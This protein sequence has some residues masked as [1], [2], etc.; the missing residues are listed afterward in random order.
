[1]RRDRRNGHRLLGRR[2]Q[3]LAYQVAPRSPEGT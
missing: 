2:G 1:M 3:I